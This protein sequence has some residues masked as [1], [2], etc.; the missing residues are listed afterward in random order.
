MKLPPVLPKSGASIFPASAPASTSSNAGFGPPQPNS[1]GL[2]AASSPPEPLLIPPCYPQH[3]SL[4]SKGPARA[5]KE[6]DL[7]SPVKSSSCAVD[8]RNGDKYDSTMM[9]GNNIGNNRPDNHMPPLFGPNGLMKPNSMPL[10][11]NLQTAPGV[12]RLTPSNL[13]PQNGN[14]VANVQNG[15]AM[16]VAMQHGAGVAKNAGSKNKNGTAPKRRT[17]STPG[18][19]GAKQPRSNNRKPTLTNQN[20]LFLNGAGPLNNLPPE[21]VDYKNPQVA[22]EVHQMFV[23]QMQA[24]SLG[25]LEAPQILTHYID[26]FVIQESLDPLPISP[27]IFDELPL[28]LQTSVD[29]SAP[30]LLTPERSTTATTSSTTNNTAATSQASPFSDDPRVTTPSNFNTSQINRQGTTSPPG[31]LPSFTSMNSNDNASPAPVL[32]N[33]QRCQTCSSQLPPVQQRYR[34]HPE[35]CGRT[36]YKARANK[37]NRNKSNLD[38]NNKRPKMEEAGCGGTRSVSV[39]SILSSPSRR[40]SESLSEFPSTSN[41]FASTIVGGESSP[42]LLEKPTADWTVEDVQNWLASLGAGVSAY[43]QAF[44]QQEIDGQALMLLQEDHLVRQLG[45]KLGPAVKIC[46]ALKNLRT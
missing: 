16:G 26:G 31:I 20:T 2:Q 37:P 43:A 18:G 28:F 12:M 10:E 1:K 44:R 46:A 40:V 17:N 11:T 6:I 41:S 4:I 24:A 29:W 27:L 13:I 8:F 3:P 21:P 22:A 19:T 34:N 5:S 14:G 36:C 23:D 45:L 33:L 35:Y 39:P 42:L 32:N 9:P 38:D 7:V 25:I 15:L 30:P